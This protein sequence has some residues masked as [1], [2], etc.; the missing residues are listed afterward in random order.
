MERLTI[1][2]ESGE[3]VYFVDKTT[4]NKLEPCEMEPHHAGVVIRR[5]NEYESTG[6][7]PEEIVGLKEEKKKPPMRDDVVKLLLKTIKPTLTELS[8]SKIGLYDCEDDDGIHY[9]FNGESYCISVE[10]EE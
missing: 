8:K 1:K 5:L 10:R 2:R 4:G 6:L 3:T 9:I 7:T